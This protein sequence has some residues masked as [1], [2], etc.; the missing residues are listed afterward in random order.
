MLTRM[1]KILRALLSDQLDHL[2]SCRNHR[3]RCSE[4][5]RKHIMRKRWTLRLKICIVCVM[6]PYGEEVWNQEKIRTQAAFWPDIPDHDRNARLIRKSDI[7]QFGWRIRRSLGDLRP[8]VIAKQEA[9]WAAL[10]TVWRTAGRRDAWKWMLQKFVEQRNQA[11]Y[12]MARNGWKSPLLPGLSNAKIIMDKIRAKEA[13]YHFVEIM[14]C[15]GGCQR[16]RVSLRCMRMCVIL[17]M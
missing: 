10:R 17:K 3:S 5:L 4:R 9:L 6:M 12:N 11:V 15:P 14:C 7:P 1:G 13:D 16:R 8:G 2:S